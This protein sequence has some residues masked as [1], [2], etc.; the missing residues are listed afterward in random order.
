YGLGVCPFVQ[1]GNTK[2]FNNGGG[3][4]FTSG[5]STRISAAYASGARVG[6][7]SWGT[8]SNSYL[9]DAQTHDKRVRDAQTGTAGNQEFSIV[10]AAGNGGSAANTVGSPSTAKNILCVGAS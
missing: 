9:T 2:V 3:A 7:N 5:T 1:L 10:F 6:S 8:S 4:G